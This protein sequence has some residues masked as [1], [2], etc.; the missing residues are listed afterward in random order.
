[1]KQTEFLA[2]TCYLLKAR[3]KSRVHRAN[4]V[5]FA[6]HWSEN[7]NPIPVHSNRNGVI[8]LDSHWKNALNSTA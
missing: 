6:S 8:T 3:E 1:M 2:I 7:F 5:G 4:G